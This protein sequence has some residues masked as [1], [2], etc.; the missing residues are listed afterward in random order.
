MLPFSKQI[1]IASDGAKGCVARLAG[2]EIPKWDDNEA[3]LDDL[4]ARIRKTI[5]YVQS[6]PAAQIDGSEGRAITITLRTG[7]VKF[8]R[9][10]PGQGT[11]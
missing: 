3:T 9:R 8:D 7:D 10:G 2:Q 11:T 6:V 1:Q 5:D 4:R